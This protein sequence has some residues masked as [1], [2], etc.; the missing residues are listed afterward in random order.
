MK[1][2]KLTRQNH[3]EPDLDELFKMRSDLENFLNEEANQNDNQWNKN[4]NIILDFQDS[5]GS[6]KL[7]DSYRIPSDARVDFCHMPTYICTAI[8]MKA[9]LTNSEA[10][11]S[12]EESALSKG[13][14][15]SCARNLVGHGFEALRGQID[16]LRIFMKAG[17]NEFMDLHSDFCPKFTEMISTIT[18]EF[19]DMESKGEFFGSWGKSYETDIKEIN[20]YFSHRKVFVYGTLMDGEGNH[21]HLENSTCLGKAT[22]EG[23]DMYDVGY[24]P[25][26]VPGDNLVIGE[27]YQVPKEDMPSIDRLEGEGILYIKKCERVTVHGEPTF[28]FVYVYNRDP[29][30]LERISAWNQKYVWYVSYGSNMLKERFKCYIEGGSFEGSRYHPPCKDTTP[31]VSIKTV[32][33]PFDMYFGHTSKSWEYGGVSFLDIKKEGNAYGVA[34]LITEEQFEHV[35]AEENSGTPPHRSNGWYTDI[36]SLGTMDGFEVKTVTNEDPRHHN[37]PCEKYINILKRGMEE[38]WP[39]M[40]DEEINN[41][42]NGCIREPEV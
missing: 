4:L 35:A 38:N 33:I 14:E 9:Y 10:F 27:L 3:N 34:Y 21:G 25:A 7:L 13:F 8:L 16:A 22:I 41:Y 2:L 30:G 11:T 12:K 39:E 40:S 28:A 6:F 42:L 32:K 31:P 36:I 5:D 37:K 26:I 17:L 19:R 24:Y 15:M 20:E 23:Y 1:M 18:S 29:S